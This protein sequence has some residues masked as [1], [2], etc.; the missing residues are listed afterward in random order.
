MLLRRITKHVK[1]QNWFAV[2][3]D[4]LIVVVGVFIKA[5]SGDVLRYQLFDRGSVSDIDYV[6]GEL[7][8]IVV[9]FGK[10]QARELRG[11]RPKKKRVI[12]ARY[13]AGLPLT[14]AR[15]MQVEEG[16]PSYEL[17]LASLSDETLNKSP[18]K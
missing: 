17:R 2:F 11:E 18:R 10:M 12:S 16:K 8:S 14:P 9:P 1:D 7:A 3:I 15:L 5:K 4:F 13:S 6:V